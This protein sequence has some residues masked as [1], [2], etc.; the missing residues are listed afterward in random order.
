LSISPALE[1][2]SWA[3]SFNVPS[4]CAYLTEEADYFD[5]SAAAAAFS[6]AA[7]LALWAF[8]VMPYSSALVLIAIYAS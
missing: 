6:L 8:S 5:H 3:F 4:S 7:S 1:A 2:F